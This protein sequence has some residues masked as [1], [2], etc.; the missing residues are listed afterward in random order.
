[1]SKAKAQ[2]HV[3]TFPEDRFF[4][5]PDHQLGEFIMSNESK[6]EL[7]LKWSKK[8]VVYISAIFGIVLLTLWNKNSDINDARH[9]CLAQA[10]TRGVRDPQLAC[11]CAMTQLSNQVSYV[12]YIPW[13]RNLVEENE[14]AGRKMIMD[15]M[16]A[17]F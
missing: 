3:R 2:R 17:C 14:K 13:I 10:S 1:M 15:A 6:N 8:K 16:K 12:H 9:M 4:E 5:L 7:P 11:D